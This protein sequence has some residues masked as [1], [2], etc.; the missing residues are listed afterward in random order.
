LKR[1]L[2]LAAAV[3]LVLTTPRAALAWGDKGHEIVA[4]IAYQ[5][6]TPSAR[7][8]VDALLQHLAWSDLKR[9]EQQDVSR[10]RD[11]FRDQGPAIMQLMVAAILPD[12]IRISDSNDPRSGWHFADW[13]IEAGHS[14]PPPS[15]NNAFNAL[16]LALLPE[17]ARPATDA[18]TRAVDLAFVIHLVGDLHQP[19]HCCTR[20]TAEGPDIRPRPD[21]DRYGDKGGN[22][23]KIA[24]IHVPGRSSAIREL[25]AYWDDLPDLGTDG[26]TVA[27]AAQAIT[28]AH[29]RTEFAAELQQPDPKEWSLEGRDLASRDVYTPEMLQQHD[30]SVYGAA[31]WE[32]AQ[33]RLALAGYR[34]ADLLNGLLG[35]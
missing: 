5:S 2:L 24:R 12:K 31:A 10:T 19:L 21:E 26:M 30:V 1:S 15:N 16:S 14:G 25:H 17:I 20:Y 18:A 13:P 29:S 35:Q 9:Q 3:L 4:W 27:Q 33:Q 22:Y 32:L 8:Q 23:F 28:V 7:Q 6:L 11:E 34:L